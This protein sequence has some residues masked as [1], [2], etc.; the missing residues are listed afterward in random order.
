MEYALRAFILVEGKIKRI[1]VN[2]LSGTHQEGMPEYAGKKIPY[3]LLIFERQERK[4]ANL[5]YH[6]GGYLIFDEEGRLDKSKGLIHSRLILAC[7]GE[8]DPKS[9]AARRAEQVR[10]ENTWYPS[11]DQ[12]NRM[13]AL[14][15]RNK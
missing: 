14:A 1:G 3:A 12:L 9:F 2:R 6:E 4:L 8:N 5:R 10:R 15:K 13:I 11:G 7:A